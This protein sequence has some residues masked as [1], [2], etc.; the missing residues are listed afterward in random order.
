[1]VL[2]LLQTKQVTLVSLIP[3]VTVF[4]EQSTQ[5]CRASSG[6]VMQVYR[7]KGSVDGVVIAGE[8]AKT[9]HLNISQVSQSAILIHSCKGNNLNQ[10]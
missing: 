6:E 7:T 8:S 9:G 1:M 4:S 2:L 3:Y 5:R 10:V